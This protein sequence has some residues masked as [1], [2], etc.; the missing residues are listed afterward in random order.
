[1]IPINKF[2]LFLQM[3]VSR[4]SPAI[5]STVEDESNV[6]TT[7]DG[8]EIRPDVVVVGVRDEEERKEVQDDIGYESGQSG[9]LV[10]KLISDNVVSS[11][12]M[13]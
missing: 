11:T 7:V 4:D 8:P 1:M 5:V 13:S 12:D 3:S 9:H 2:S 6:A 10:A